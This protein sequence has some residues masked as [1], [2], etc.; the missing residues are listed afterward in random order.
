MSFDTPHRPDL[1]MQHE[2]WTFDGTG[3]RR[4]QVAHGLLRDTP[5]PA[6]SAPAPGLLF[7]G[8]R[9]K[10]NRRLYDLTPVARLEFDVRHP[11]SYALKARLRGAGIVRPPLGLAVGRE[12]DL[13]LRAQQPVLS[14]VTAIFVGRSGRWVGDP[15]ID[16]LESVRAFRH[17]AVAGDGASDPM[18]TERRSPITGQSGEP[19]RYNGRRR[20]QWSF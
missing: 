19:C 10:A 5:V 4:W 18:P 13:S 17:R 16:D 11:K 15:E 7:D 14:A 3:A 6:D 1:P 8:Q 2:E 9:G 20:P 12:Q